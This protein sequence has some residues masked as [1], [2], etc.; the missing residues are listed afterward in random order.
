MA[1]LEAHRDEPFC[2]VLSWGP[3]HDPYDCVPERFRRL[4]DPAAIALRPNVPEA[5][6]DEARRDIAGYYAHVTALDGLM[7]RLMTRLDELG[8]ADSTLV[9]FTSDHG[10]MLGSQGHVRKQKPWEESIGVPLIMRRPG[11]VPAGRTTGA[12]IGIVDVLPTILGLA[13]AGDT[14]GMDGRDLSGAATG[15]VPGREDVLL[16]E[17]CPVDEAPTGG[18]AEWRGL[19]T[20]RYTYARTLDG[21]WVLYDNEADPYQIRNLVGDAGAANLLRDLDER[22]GRRLRESG[23]PFLPWPETI[24]SLDLVSAWNA[25]ERHLHGEEARVLDD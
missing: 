9:V 6:A 1:F 10:D 3:P 2:L 5:V 13:G 18:I 17:P 12:L 4:H 19:R 11:L 20:P 7:G 25:R 23:D 14:G 15:D 22:L 8:L 21:P 24:R 16:G